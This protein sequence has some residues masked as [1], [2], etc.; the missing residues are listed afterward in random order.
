MSLK[1][2]MES[3]S[4]GLSEVV[5]VGSGGGEAVLVRG[6]QKPIA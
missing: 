5:V 6:A 3:A 4:N 2:F 1:S